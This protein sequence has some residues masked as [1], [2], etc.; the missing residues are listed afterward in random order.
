[1]CSS[2]LY[3]MDETG[4]STTAA[5]V[6]ELAQLLVDFAASGMKLSADDLVRDPTEQWTAAPFDSD[7]E[8][9]ASLKQALAA[10][11]KSDKEEADRIAR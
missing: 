8:E 2:D 7:D 11:V 6:Q 3:N 10:R 9:D 1:M 4:V 5:D